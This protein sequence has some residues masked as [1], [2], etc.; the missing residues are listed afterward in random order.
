L[1]IPAA[2]HTVLNAVKETPLLRR[3]RGQ[4]VALRATTPNPS[5]A[6]RGTRD[7]PDTDLL[8][9]SQVLRNGVYFSHFMA[10]PLYAA[11]V[12]LGSRWEELGEMNSPLTAL[13]MGGFHG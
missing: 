12:L 10:S 1:T 2:T 13:P 8:A 7:L 4:G 6:R 9:H 11:M 5:L 3:R